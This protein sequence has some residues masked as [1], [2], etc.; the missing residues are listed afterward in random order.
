MRNFL[1]KKKG[2]IIIFTIICILWGIFGPIQKGAAMYALNRYFEQKGIGAED[3]YRV[4]ISNGLDSCGYALYVEFSKEKGY[5]YEYTYTLTL[6]SKLFLFEG[7][8][9]NPS[10]P[11]RGVGATIYRTVEQ[12][13]E[14]EFVFDKI[15]L[16]E[17]DYVNEDY[18][19]KMDYG[20]LDFS[21][22]L[23]TKDL[24]FKA[25]YYPIYIWDFIDVRGILGLT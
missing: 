16:Y 13:D 9:E 11:N 7:V 12:G 18:I 4:R 10:D 6:S 21:R 24:M 23:L 1:R 3:I 2:I 8:F 5:T 20:L 19:G 22:D 25:E 14:I 15:P 17:P